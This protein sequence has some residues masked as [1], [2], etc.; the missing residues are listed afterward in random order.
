MMRDRIRHRGTHGR[1]DMT[2]RGLLRLAAWGALVTAAPVPVRALAPSEEQ[3]TLAFYNTHTGEKLRVVYWEDGAYMKP[4]LAEIDHHL[5]D[6]RTDDV[7]PIDPRLLDLLYDL[8]GALD[9]QE[10]FH[11]ISG[12]RSPATNAMLAANSGGV[13]KKS[14]HMRGMAIDI[15]LPGRSVADLR[16]AALAQRAGGVGAYPRS[17]FVHVDVGHVRS[18]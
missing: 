1:G 17:G 18:W 3:R 5:R 13:G 14:F 10:P 9:T 15:S 16:R 7:K 12:Y 8:R 2:R 11:V 6:H 4:S